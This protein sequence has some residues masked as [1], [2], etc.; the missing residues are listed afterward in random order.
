MK[1]QERL[2][3]IL[4]DFSD[5][6]LT[7]GMISRDL[8]FSKSYINNIRNGTNQNPSDSFYDYFKIRFNVNPQ[9]LRTGEGERYLAGGKQN[10]TRQAVLFAKILQLE[11]QYRDAVLLLIDGILAG[12]G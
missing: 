11:P 4:H 2:D 8:N 9:W 3:R 1:L 12:K 7:P 10:N 5:I 6:K